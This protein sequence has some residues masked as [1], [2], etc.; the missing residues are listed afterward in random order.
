MSLLALEETLFK[1]FPGKVIMYAD[2]GI[3]YGDDLTADELSLKLSSLRMGI[4][5]N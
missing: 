1:W 3:I 5:T 2:D 4:S